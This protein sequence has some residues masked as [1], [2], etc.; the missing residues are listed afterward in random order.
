MLFYIS[1]EVLFFLGKD[2]IYFNKS[3]HIQLSR[4]LTITP[5]V[6][7]ISQAILLEEQKSYGVS[8]KIF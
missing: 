1:F 5:I 6:K 3:K 4:R 7:K 2:T 8:Y